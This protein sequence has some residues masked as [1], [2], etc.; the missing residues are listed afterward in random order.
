MLG[1]AL[2]KSGEVPGAL[3]AFR[4][5]ARTPAMRASAEYWMALAD[6]AAG[7]GRELR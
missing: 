4:Q 6:A 1:V 5:A 2:L 3:A 7:D